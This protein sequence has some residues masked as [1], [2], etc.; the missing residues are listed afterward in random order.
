M[1][2]DSNRTEREYWKRLRVAGVDLTPYEGELCPF[3][4]PFYQPMRLHLLAAYCA[5][6]D[7]ARQV[8]VAAVH[9]AGNSFLD[10]PQRELRHIGTTVT[11]AWKRLLSNPNDFRVCHAESL[12]DGIRESGAFSDLADYLAKRY[13]V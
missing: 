8:D 9:F 3:A 10:T 6:Q 11:E 2:G 5:Q 12:A 7:T 1:S 13:G 4:G